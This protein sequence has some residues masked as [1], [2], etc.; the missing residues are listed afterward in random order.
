VVGPAQPC[1]SCLLRPS[2]YY[3][4]L[5]EPFSEGE[6][7]ALLR[8]LP[9]TPRPYIFEPGPFQPG[10]DA[11]QLEVGDPLEFDLL[12]FGQATDLQIYVLLA[13]E[14]MAACGLGR[15][16]APFRLER[17]LCLTPDGSW[18]TVLDEGRMRGRGGS[19][20]SFPPTNGVAGPRAVLRF[21]TPTRL[22]VEDEHV[23]STDFPELVEAMLRR[24]MEVAHFHVIGARIDENIE[25]LLAK[26]RGVRTVS[27]HLRW[28]DWERYNVQQKTLMNMGGFMGTVELEGDLTPFAP[29]LRT[30]E[31]IH[32]GRGTPFGLG[33]V[34]V[35]STSLE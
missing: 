27:S 34:V 14:R 35:E 26:A 22:R 20:P 3:T 32:L 28:H 23:E 29:L 4:K 9:I 6:P 1:E 12:L 25:P 31:I 24:V 33:R 7:P 5:F 13:I 15:N 2:C 10:G 19:R 11:R 18:K 17:A 30:A 21:L 16:R 8:G